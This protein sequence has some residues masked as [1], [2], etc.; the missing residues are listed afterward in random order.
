MSNIAGETLQQCPNARLHCNILIMPL[1]GTCLSSDSAV[2]QAK[3]VRLESR[4][5]GLLAERDDLQFRVKDLKVLA[6]PLL[7]VPLCKLRLEAA[8]L[9]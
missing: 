3:S 8:S 5:E 6:C 1:P 7:T 9:G 2:Q 4:V